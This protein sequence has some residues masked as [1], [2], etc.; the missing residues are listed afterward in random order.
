MCGWEQIENRFIGI[1]LRD[2]AGTTNIGI[3]QLA[4]IQLPSVGG[5]KQLCCCRTGAADTKADD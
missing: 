3:W 1:R 2:S 4:Q 5:T